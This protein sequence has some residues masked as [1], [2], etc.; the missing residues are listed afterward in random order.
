M[1]Y[2]SIP[3]GGTSGDLQQPSFGVGVMQ[4]DYEHN[5]GFTFLSNEIPRIIDLSFPGN[6]PDSLRFNGI[7][8]LQQK[9]IQ[10]SAVT[11]TAIASLRKS[12]RAASGAA[13]STTLDTDSAARIATDIE[14]QDHVTNNRTAVSEDKENRWVVNIVSLSNKASADHIADKALSMDIKTEQQHVTVKGKHY[15]RVQITGFSTATEAAAYADI[16][17]KKLGLKGAW[18]TKR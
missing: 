13:A 10:N 17:Q 7:N 5:S 18:I 6:K 4:A 15:W 11:T 12:A 9:L 1:V 3:L 2:L 14:R 8:T 16:A